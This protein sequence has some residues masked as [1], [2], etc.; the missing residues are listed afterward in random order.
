MVQYSCSSIVN[1]LSKVRFLP[2]T[3]Y[4]ALL[5][6]HVAWPSLDVMW[7]L[8]LMQHLVKGNMYRVLFCVLADSRSL[9]VHS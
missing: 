1:I 9:T 4:R 5:L 8:A 7:C 3:G 6:L 2:R